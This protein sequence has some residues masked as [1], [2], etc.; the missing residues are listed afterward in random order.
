MIEILAGLGLI[1]V[2]V[3]GGH[4]TL[5]GARLSGGQQQRI[6]I[7]RAVLKD[8]PIPILDEATSSVDAAIEAL[9]QEA[10]DRLTLRRT[11]LVI[12]LRDGRV[13]AAGSHDDLM[14]EGGRYAE[15]V[16]RQQLSARRCLESTAEVQLT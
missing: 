6:S 4:L 16:R 10:L 11:S 12:V 15:L 7:A 5:R 8:A 14:V 2:V 9:I 13:A 3:V 1:L